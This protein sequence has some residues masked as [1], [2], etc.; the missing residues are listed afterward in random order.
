M[1][2]IVSEPLLFVEKRQSQSENNYFLTLD[3]IRGAGGVGMKFQTGK[4]STT[5]V[6]FALE[7]HNARIGWT[8]DIAENPSAMPLQRKDLSGGT[9]A[10]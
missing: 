1:L 5:T 10:L 6:E 7:Y 9:A 4:Y 8:A 2:Q 3:P